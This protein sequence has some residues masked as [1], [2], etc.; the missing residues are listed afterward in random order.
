[1]SRFKKTDSLYLQVKSVILLTCCGLLW[2][3]CE[4]EN[5]DREMLMAPSLIE[6][7]DIVSSPPQ[8]SFDPFYKKYLNA[9][10]IPVVSSENVADS[11]LILARHTIINMTAKRPDVLAQMVL[12]RARVGIIAEIEETSD[13]PEYSNIEDKEFFNSRGRGYGGGEL[14]P[15]A[16]ASEEA[17]L[18]KY[19]DAGYDLLQHEFAHLIHS[20]GLRYAIPGFQK[21]LKDAFKKAKKEGLWV[22]TYAA[23]DE[24]EYFAESTSI[25]FNHAVQS[26]P[27]G[28]GVYNHIHT[29]EEL[30]EYDP[31]MYNI[32]KEV[33]NETDWKPLGLKGNYNEEY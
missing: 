16:S 15:F 18:N 2:S 13:L 20:S 9:N 19:K 32:L 22:N 26:I 17:M 6:T 29:R 23:T 10:G 5:A 28:D 30:K 14:E 33:Y 12:N 4:M 1:M 7:G 31:R 27:E 24:M 21:K 25:W 8:G 3:A 11:A